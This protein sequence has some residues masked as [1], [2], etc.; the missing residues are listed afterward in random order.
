MS[1][2]LF[3][4]S[5]RDPYTLAAVAMVLLIIASVA[6]FFPARRAATL[7]PVRAIKTE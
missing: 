5:E 2:L 4:L 6:G 7:D 3:G 1:A